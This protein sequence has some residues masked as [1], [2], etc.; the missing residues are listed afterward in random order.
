MAR[1][2]IK[3][4]TADDSVGLTEEDLKRLYKDERATGQG[5][6]GRSEGD[7]KPLDFS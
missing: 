5:D 1:K 4:L 3:P 6:D 2:K 7:P